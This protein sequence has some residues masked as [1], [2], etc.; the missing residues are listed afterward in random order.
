MPTDASLP[1]DP[2]DMPQTGSLKDCVDWQLAGLRR[3]HALAVASLV[4]QRKDRA[5]HL[6]AGRS[7]EAEFADALVSVLNRH[8][9]SCALTIAKL[10]SIQRRLAPGWGF[11]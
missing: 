3:T 4:D 11:E 9:K 5:Q 7:L 8:V 10:E 1:R 6:K 2:A